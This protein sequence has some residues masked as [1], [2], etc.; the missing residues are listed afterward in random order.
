MPTVS[1]D[2]YTHARLKEIKQIF[3]MKG[4]NKSMSDII[5]D[6]IEDMYSKIK[7]TKK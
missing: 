4:I 5:R 3:K 1:I 2:K 7:D 6:V